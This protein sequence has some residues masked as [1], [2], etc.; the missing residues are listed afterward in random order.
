MEKLTVMHTMTL[1]KSDGIERI[2]VDDGVVLKHEGHIHVLNQTAVRI[3]DLVDGSRMHE[4][5]VS[6]MIE[7][8]NGT[9]VRGYVMDFIQALMKANLIHE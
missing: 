5:I 3:F 9:D 4:T 7:E 1:H 2:E 8:N 6:I